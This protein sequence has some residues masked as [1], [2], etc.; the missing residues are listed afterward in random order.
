M[1]G[2]RGSAAQDTLVAL[3]GLAQAVGLTLFVYGVA[4]SP[5]AVAV[6]PSAVLAAPGAALLATF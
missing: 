1:L 4:S 3:D 6:T 5:V 2:S